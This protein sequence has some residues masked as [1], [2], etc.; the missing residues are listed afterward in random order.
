MIQA[1]QAGYRNVVAQMGTAMTEAQI[2]RLTPRFARKIVLALD[3]DEAG[4]SATRRS[5]EVARQTLQRD[6]A[7]K[8]SVDVRILQVPSGKDP[9]DFLRESPQE[10][11]A[12]VDS[13]QDVADLRD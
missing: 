1:H 12:L 6:F 8:L 7:G 13:A 4:Q 5:L 9:D 11:G 2:R 3:A 10:W